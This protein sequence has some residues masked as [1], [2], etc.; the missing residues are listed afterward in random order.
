MK[1]KIGLLIAILALLISCQ[2]SSAPSLAFH[3][4]GM[5][6]VTIF[7]PKGEGTTFDMDYYIRKH[8][9]LVQ[10]VYGDALKGLTIDKGIGGGSP[11][12]AAPYMA[13]GHLYFENV[14]AYEEGLKK[15]RETFAADFPKY[16]NVMPV[17]QI[18]EVIQ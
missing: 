1:T 5:I 9:P 6:K 15:N 8:M 4:K 11:E 17:V 14:A 2:Q 18:S 13:M 10:R 3:K 12:T 7:Y 16:T